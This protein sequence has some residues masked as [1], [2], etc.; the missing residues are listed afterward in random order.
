MFNMH[1]QLHCCLAGLSIAAPHY[2]ELGPEFNMHAFSTATMS[3]ALHTKPLNNLHVLFVILMLLLAQHAGHG[4]TRCVTAG[5]Q[6]AA[7][8]ARVARAPAG[9]V[10]HQTAGIFAFR[11]CRMQA[12][13]H[14]LIQHCHKGNTGTSDNALQCCCFLQRTSYG[15]TVGV[16]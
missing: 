14:P 8:T 12:T 13:K 9:R 4:V 1:M 2:F 5:C 3:Y 11:V 6:L 10:L 15:P 7:A 16:C